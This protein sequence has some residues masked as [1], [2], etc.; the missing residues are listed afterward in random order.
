M[1]THL[2]RTFCQDVEPCVLAQ[3]ALR[4]FLAVS[5]L[6]PTSFAL[7]LKGLKFQ[8]CHVCQHSCRCAHMD[9]NCARNPG[10]DIWYRN[11]PSDPVE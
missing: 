8:N 1:D 10:C 9:H 3:D 2:F 4:L 6:C 11:F 5:A 7:S